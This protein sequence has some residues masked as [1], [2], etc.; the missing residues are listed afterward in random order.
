M[1]LLRKKSGHPFGTVPSTISQ[2]FES[3][4]A[5][6]PLQYTKLIGVVLDG[7]NLQFTIDGTRRERD[8]I[9]GFVESSFYLAAGSRNFNLSIT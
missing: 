3:L 2:V 5:S 4:N 6:L 7:N 9:K 1:Q 8:L